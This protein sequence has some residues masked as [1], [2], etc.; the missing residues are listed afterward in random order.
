MALVIVATEPSGV[1][2]RQCSYFR[3]L[4]VQWMQPGMSRSTYTTML[5]LRLVALLDWNGEDCSRCTWLL[6]TS[7]R[8]W[9]LPLGYRQ[10]MIWS[11]PPREIHIDHRVRLGIL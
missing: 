8:R 2:R 3:R 1:Q 7:L 4:R 5:V 6:I 11:S 10:V 9:R